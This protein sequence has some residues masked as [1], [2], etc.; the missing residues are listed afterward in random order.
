MEIIKHK[1]ED[2]F[3][4]LVLS[5]L[6]PTSSSLSNISEVNRQS[7]KEFV[8]YLTKLKKEEIIND[9]YFSELVTIACANFVE[10]EVE[11]RVAKSIN[12]RLMVYFD[13][14]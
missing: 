9:R 2:E 1:K 7:L 13:K 6:K 12:N 10:N 8:N 11:F 4:N 5:S 14:F 3:I